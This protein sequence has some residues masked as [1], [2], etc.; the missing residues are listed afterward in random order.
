MRD[1]TVAMLV[2]R[3]TWGA[4]PLGTRA[5][6]AHPLGTRVVARDGPRA[7]GGVQGSGDGPGAGSS[8]PRAVAKDGPHVLGKARRRIRAPGR[9]LRRH[10]RECWDEPRTLEA[11]RPPAAI[12]CG[13]SRATIRIPTSADLLH[14]GAVASI[15]T[16]AMLKAIPLVPRYAGPPR[17]HWA[18]WAGGPRRPSRT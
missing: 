5:V 8:G 2:H 1:R 3:I 16:P 17:P 4:Q 12:S 7:H 13:S 14:I 10:L 11:P 18:A 15:D 6:G 9:P